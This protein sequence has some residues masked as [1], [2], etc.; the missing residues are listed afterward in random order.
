MNNNNLDNLID[1]VASTFKNK[2]LGKGED[3]REKSKRQKVV[4]R[5]Y[6][7]FLRTQKDNTTDESLLFNTCFHIYVKDEDFRKQE[8]TFSFTARDVMKKINRKIMELKK[9]YPDF[10]PHSNYWQFQFAPLDA[11]GKLDSSLFNQDQEQDLG[12][13][14][15]PIIS[16]LYPLTDV[17]HHNDNQR[18]V[19]TVH[20]KDS[21][22]IK[23]WDVNLDVLRE[24]EVRGR[25]LFRFKFTLDGSTEQMDANE[26]TNS[27]L[28]TVATLK[29]EGGTFLGNKKMYAMTSDKLFIYGRVGEPDT[30]GKEIARLDSDEVLS[31]HVIIRRTRQGGFEVQAKG[32]TVL[33]EV[34]LPHLLDVWKPL[35]NN[36]AL[37]LNGVIQLRFLIAQN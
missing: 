19:A 8:Q 31:P 3:K 14:G 6:G 28:Q 10:V 1:K 36:S 30:S 4:D 25:C 12:Q 29:A 34:S 11:D 26:K 18:V 13:D 33:N 2:L 9:Y 17:Q 23:D 20:S 24:M 27:N 15:M 5:I 22:T 37:L 7:E 16:T 35:P 32:D 21:V